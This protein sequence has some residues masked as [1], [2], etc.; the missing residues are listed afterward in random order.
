MHASARPVVVAFD[1]SPPSQAAVRAA[2][3]P[4]ADRRLIVVSV[5]EPGI[6][7]T[8]LATP[9]VSGFVP[10]IPNPEE[11]ATVDRIQ[12]DHA[13]A[14]A[15]AGAALARELG[16]TAEAHAIPDASD[17]GATIDGVART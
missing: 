4:F 1:G 16:A 13:S 8:T 14:A 3:E 2:V 11:I 9:D 5:W 10:P 7:M 12:S 17:V 6:A 15:E